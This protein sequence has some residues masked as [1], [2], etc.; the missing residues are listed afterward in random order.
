MAGPGQTQSFEGDEYKGILA[1]DRRSSQ[2]QIAEG[3]A[4]G[5]KPIQKIVIALDTEYTE[6]NPFPVPFPFR[7][8][9]VSAATDTSVTVYL[10]PNQPDP[11]SEDVPLTKK[12]SIDFSEAIAKGFLFWTAQPGKSITLHFFRDAAFRSGSQISQNSGGV[13]V[14]EGSNVGVPAR[15]AL[16]PGAAVSIAQNTNRFALTVYNDS[17]DTVYWAGDNTVTDSGATKGMPLAPGASIKF[18]NTAAVYFYQPS[19]GSASQYLLYNEET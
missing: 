4:F 12:D 16:T 17:P 11:S 8:V 6:Q 15:K 9:F 7:S 1:R 10:R 2:A 19:T 5:H 14:S 13:S 3:H 18:L